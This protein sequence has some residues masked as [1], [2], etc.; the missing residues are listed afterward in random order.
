MAEKVC[1]GMQ[2]GCR[3]SC[4]W[5]GTWVG[6][7]YMMMG[8]LGM[9]ITGGEGM[10]KLREGD[11]CL[12]DMAT[13]DERDMVRVGCLATEIWRYSEALRLDGH[14]MSR[15]L[16]LGGSAEKTAGK[17]WCDWV[18]LK[19]GVVGDT[20]GLMKRGQLVHV[21]VLGRWFCEHSWSWQLVAWRER[22]ELMIGKPAGSDKG[23][24]VVDVLEQWS[25]ERYEA[26][27]EGGKR[28]VA[29]DDNDQGALWAKARRSHATGLGLDLGCPGG[30]ALGG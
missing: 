28:S 23:M 7:L 20:R 6:M 25:W 4:G 13:D 16:E 21:P 30:S 5:S 27:M 2:S 24:L 11:R 18:R 10:P 15:Q 14:S 22:G 19:L 17:V 8:D 3:T 26:A 1:G 9:R 12:V 29:L